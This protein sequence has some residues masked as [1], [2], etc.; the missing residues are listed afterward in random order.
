MGSRCVPCD[1]SFDND[2]SLKQ[3]KRTSLAHAFNYV[4]C[5]RRFNSEK[6][7]QRHL[8]YSPAH[9]PSFG[10]DDCDR[11][12]DSEQALQ[13]HMRVSPIHQQ[14]TETPLDI[15][16]HAFPTFDYDPSLPP[17]TSYAYLRRHEGWQRGS[18][19]SDDAWNC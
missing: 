13:Q 5:N 16:F 15:F 19:G 7:L 14:D 17:A 10:C 6:L 1:Q 2:T 9:T 3:H 12:F 11:S 8:R 18:A 4:L